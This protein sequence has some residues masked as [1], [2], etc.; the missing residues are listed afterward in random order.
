MKMMISD[1]QFNFKVRRVL[2]SPYRDERVYWG[3]MA[4][5]PVSY[6]I[7]TERLCAIKKRQE[8]IQWLQKNFG[9]N[10]VSLE[11][12]VGANRSDRWALYVEDNPS[13][14]W[15]SVFL[16]HAT[17]VAKFMLMHDTT[18]DF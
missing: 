9:A 4:A 6:K 1:P 5:V 3:F 12:L 16:V 2:P 10:Y 11:E 18:E 8:I 13:M 14:V 15:L 17:D 7:E